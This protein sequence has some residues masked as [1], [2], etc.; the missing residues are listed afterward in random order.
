MPAA[1]PPGPFAG[2]GKNPSRRGA[3]DELCTPAAPCYGMATPRRHSG[4]QRE[5]NYTWGWE[6]RGGRAAATQFPMGSSLAGGGINSWQRR[7]QHAGYDRAARLRA[8][9]RLPLHSVAPGVQSC[10]AVMRCGRE[11]GATAK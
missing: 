8:T 9:L 4:P 1:A 6:G 5:I 2:G 11:P 7:G 3:I 10:A